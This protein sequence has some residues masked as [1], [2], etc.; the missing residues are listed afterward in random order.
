[1]PTS[2]D[3]VNPLLE[4]NPSDR[5]LKCTITFMSSLGQEISCGVSQV[6]YIIKYNDFIGIMP[7]DINETPVSTT[8]MSELSKEFD[9]YILF[10]IQPSV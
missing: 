2:A 10:V 1:M 7:A 8:T 3:V 9:T 6:N 5:L 4:I